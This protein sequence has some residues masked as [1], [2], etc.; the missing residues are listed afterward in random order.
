MLPI[1]V[2]TKELVDIIEALSRQGK[3]DDLILRLQVLYENNQEEGTNGN[4]D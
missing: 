3:A 1:R 4:Q 2:T